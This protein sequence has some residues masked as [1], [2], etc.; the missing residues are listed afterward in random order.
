MTQRDNS[1]MSN[2]SRV[3]EVEQLLK[4]AIQAGYWYGGLQADPD[5]QLLYG[6][7]EFERLVRICEERR[8]Q[9]MANAVPTLK[10]IIGL[11]QFRMA[12]L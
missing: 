6:E 3:E 11:P 8:A 12:G 9:A 4:E 2:L 5:F 7:A 10:L 1:Q